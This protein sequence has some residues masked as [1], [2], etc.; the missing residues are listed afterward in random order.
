MSEYFS[1]EEEN[2]P[3]R[4]EVTLEVVRDAYRSYDLPQEY[5]E[6][7]DLLED[8]NELIATASIWIQEEGYDVDEFLRKIG[9]DVV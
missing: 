9:A 4:D 5:K 8:V 6:E 2:N 3:E 7:L 1:P